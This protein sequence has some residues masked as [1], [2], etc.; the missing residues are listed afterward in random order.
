MTVL[1]FYSIK[2]RDLSVSRLSLAGYDWELISDL[3]VGVMASK[4]D[5]IEALHRPPRRLHV[6]R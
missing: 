6:V 1:T 3:E 2:Q 4:H 5:T